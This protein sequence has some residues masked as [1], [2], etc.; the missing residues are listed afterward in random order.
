MKYGLQVIV[1]VGKCSLLKWRWD[2]AEISLRIL[3][4]RPLRSVMLATI[5]CA[6][7]RYRPAIG[8][9]RYPVKKIIIIKKIKNCLP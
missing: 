3:V 4:E 8:E 7:P 5:V 1:L 6:S 9:S 2:G